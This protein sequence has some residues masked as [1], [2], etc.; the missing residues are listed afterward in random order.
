MLTAKKVPRLHLTASTR[1]TQI[2]F[3]NGAICFSYRANA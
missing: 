3:T 2:V 1:Q